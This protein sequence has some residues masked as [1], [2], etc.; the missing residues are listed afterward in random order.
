M[1]DDSD[2]ISIAS[3][4]PLRE[5]VGFW[6]VAFCVGANTSLMSRGSNNSNKRG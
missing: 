3:S 4:Q 2:D 5:K 6:G 1:F